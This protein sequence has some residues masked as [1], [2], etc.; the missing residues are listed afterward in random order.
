[1]DSIY[2]DKV[3][4]VRVARPE[5]F[6][7]KI[8]S[9]VPAGAT[10][11]YDVDLPPGKWTFGVVANYTAATAA[12]YMQLKVYTNPE[13]TRV[14]A[15]L[16]GAEIVNSGMTTVPAFPTGENGVHIFWAAYNYVGSVRDI[17]IPF[18]AQL[19]FNKNGGTVSDLEFW[20]L[21][22]RVA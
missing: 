20:V 7:Q 5:F 18:G 12:P 6:M 15:A 1:V 16:A 8:T 11:T 22:Q 14:S 21:A 17:N 9:T 19:T 3:E 13:Q 4:G 10:E 2:L